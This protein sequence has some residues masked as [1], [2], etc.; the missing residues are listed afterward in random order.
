[1]LFLLPGIAFNHANPAVLQV[2]TQPLQTD[3]AVR[4]ESELA[5]TIICNP[6]THQ[7]GP[8]L[9]THTQKYNI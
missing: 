5:Q 7:L 2:S 6:E 9:I 4:W 8:V 1:M 3:S